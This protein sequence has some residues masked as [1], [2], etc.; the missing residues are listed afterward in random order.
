MYRGGPTDGLRAAIATAGAWVVV[1]ASSD[2]FLHEHAP[3][4]A[5]LRPIK[6][7]ITA[8]LRRSSLQ[9]GTELA[10]RWFRR[11]PAEAYT[12]EGL[13]LPEAALYDRMHRLQRAL[14]EHRRDAAQS[15][16]EVLEVEAPGHRLALSARRTLALKGKEARRP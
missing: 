5:V 7:Y 2:V 8:D 3:P 1:N 9:R 13:E 12:F 11:L 14:L 6:H 15:E 16:C 4:G 10:A